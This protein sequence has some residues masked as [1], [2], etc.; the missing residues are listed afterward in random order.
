M[1]QFPHESDELFRR[2]KAEEINNVIGLIAIAFMGVLA[3]CI[4]ITLIAHTIQ[5]VRILLK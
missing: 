1:K 5:E 3:V 2:R 4:S